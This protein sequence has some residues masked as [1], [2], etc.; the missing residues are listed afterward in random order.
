MEKLCDRTS[1]ILPLPS[2]PHWAPTTTAV[3]PRFT[4]NAHS[5][6]VTVFRRLKYTWEIWTGKF[7]LLIDFN[8]EVTLSAVLRDQSKVMGTAQL[9]S[10]ETFPAKIVIRASDPSNSI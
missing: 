4:G 6:P 3:L 2:S 1:T 10:R 5:S 9:P 8:R 7:L